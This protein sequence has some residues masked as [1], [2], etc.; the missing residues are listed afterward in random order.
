MSHLKYFY[1]EAGMIENIF[2]LAKNYLGFTNPIEYTNQGDPNSAAYVTQEVMKDNQG[3]VVEVK[4]ADQAVKIMLENIKNKDKMGDYVD[5][6]KKEMPEANNVSIESIYK[7]ISEGLENLTLEKVIQD[8]KKYEEIIKLINVARNLTPALGRA[9]E[10]LAH[11]IQGHLDVAKGKELASEEVA[12]SKEHQGQEGIL[13]KLN[14]K[15]PN[16]DNNIK[17]IEKILTELPQALD[18]LKNMQSASMPADDG[19]INNNNTNIS[20]KASIINNDY[21]KLIKISNTLDYIGK[22]KEADALDLI[23]EALSK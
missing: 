9:G 23:I 18:K 21:Q 15:F 19:I 17:A 20:V 3:N 22:Y 4:D 13:S 10:I 16:L 2:D 12:H 14:Q 5:R 7:K 6:V 1:K 8:P 11:E